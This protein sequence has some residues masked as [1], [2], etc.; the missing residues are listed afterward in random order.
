MQ[1]SIRK[2]MT[3]GAIFL[4]A[5]LFL[6][7]VTV[8]I[9]K[10]NLFSH[11]E[12]VKVNFESVSGLKNGDPVRVLGMEAGTVD[13]MRILPDNTVKVVLKLSE[14]IELRE[15]YRITIEESSILGG[16]FIGIDPGTPGKKVVNMKTTLKGEVISAGLD[17]LGVFIKENKDE[18]RE[19]LSK[20]AKIV[21][22]ASEGKGTL[23]KLLVDE[24]LYNN[25]KDTSESLKNMSKKVESGEGNLGKFL[26]DDQLYIDLKDSV[27]SVKKT[28]K[29]IES[30]KGFLGKLIYD[31]KLAQQVSDAGDSV[32][33]LF[34][35]VVK[36]K[37][38]LGV[39][40][41]YY[42]ESKATISDVFLRIEPRESKYF[43]LGGSILSLDKNGDVSFDKQSQDKDQIFIKAN[44]Q[45]AYRFFED[46][47]TFRTGL[48]EGKFG[49]AIDY[50]EPVSD[51]FITKFAFSLEARD[52]YNSV[53]DE[54]IDENLPA[55]MV[56]AYGSLTLWNHFK[57]YAGTSRLTSDTPEFMTGITF[58]YLDE[59]IKSFV[60]LLGISR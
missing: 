20:G 56:R 10:L 47:F 33:K 31:E 30:N 7:F 12:Y 2:E 60:T 52:G 28:L 4:A 36:T 54:K 17:A 15:D 13:R 50:E 6:I 58:E 38:F 23:G 29:Q 16:N 43:L 9:S 57:V 45:I 22:D 26:N 11:T 44:V 48:I 8:S 37:V 46:S 49:G 41:K 5:I 1:N 14:A 55:A 27:E 51:S 25:L 18:V 19:L 39:D 59:D 3:L 32:V 24:S 42:P 35:P 53:A 21:K 40:S 34:E